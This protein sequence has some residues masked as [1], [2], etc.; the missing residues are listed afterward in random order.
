MRKNHGELFFGKPLTLRE[1]ILLGQAARG[2]TAKSSAKELHI[3][4]ETVRTYRKI[5]IA[6]LGAKNMC[7]AVAE[8]FRRGILKV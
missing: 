2:E 8:G 4:Y 5:L 1:Q 7:H 3:G 6:K